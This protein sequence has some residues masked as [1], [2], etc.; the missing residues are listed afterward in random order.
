MKKSNFKMVLSLLVSVIFLATMSASSQNL[1]KGNTQ[2]KSIALI[3]TMIGKIVQSPIPLLDAGPF[4]KKTNSIAPL[5]VKEE[6]NSIDGFRDEVAA[7][8]KK[9]F[10]CDV[11]YGKSLTSKPEYQEITKKY[12]FSDNLKIDDD[13][14]SRIYM[15]SDETN[16]F[17]FDNGKKVYN[18][19]KDEENTTNTT[20]EICKSLGTDLIAVSYSSMYVRSYGMFGGHA[21]IAMYTSIFLF[22]NEGKLVSKSDRIDRETVRAA[23]TDIMEYKAVLK[24]FPQA[25]DKMMQ[26][27]AKF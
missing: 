8:L 22:N 21:Q 4:N 26:K 20:A 6:E 27:A 9:Y 14:F 15:A 23:G 24:L 17:K 16:F 12:N 11:V 2:V 13:N 7:S 25:L 18:F 10:N 1:Q 3:S 5:I 19:L